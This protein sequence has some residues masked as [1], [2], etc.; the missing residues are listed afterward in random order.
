MS[1]FDLTDRESRVLCAVVR[2][3][4]ANGLPVGSHTVVEHDGLDLSAATVRNVMGALEERGYI[5]HPHTSA[6]RIPTDAGYRYYVDHL[7]RPL[8]LSGSERQRIDSG[9]RERD[10]A[11]MRRLLQAVA[12]ALSKIT[13]QAGV[14]LAPNLHSGLFRDV[15]VCQVGERR[16][17]LHL[18]LDGGIARSAIVHT[19]FDVSADVLA[20][21]C[22]VLNRRLRGEPL[23]ELDSALE[24]PATPDGEYAL[25]LGA[26]GRMIAEGDDD[27][28]FV[29][30]IAVLL[31]Q[32]EF[33]TDDRAGA[34]AAILDDCAALRSVLRLHAPAAGEVRVTIGVEHT[35]PRLQ[36]V[37]VAR[38]R[39]RVAGLDG[40]LGVLGS[41]RMPYDLVTAAVTH[42]AGTL[43]IMQW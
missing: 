29:D 10:P 39:Y 36:Q 5:T 6:G 21:V 31:R 2:H 35:Q 8:D 25:F 34:I 3:Y 22:E 19:D 26:I 15:H 23:S 33:D 30:G 38:A 42:A 14:V 4:V 20:R 27:Q 18:A 17:V 7:M 11:D 9:I 13:G 41:T 43:D 37:S 32:P 40:V 1:A 16:Y 24:H 28:V 12:R